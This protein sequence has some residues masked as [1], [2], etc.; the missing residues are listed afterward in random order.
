MADTLVHGQALRV[1][2]LH[3]FKCCDITTT[4]RQCATCR[5]DEHWPGTQSLSSLPDGRNRTHH[6]SF[7]SVQAPETQAFRLS[8]EVV[9]VAQEQRAV[10]VAGFFQH[11][12]ATL[13]HLHCI[14]RHGLSSRNT[15]PLHQHRQRGKKSGS[16]SVSTISPGRSRRRC[17]AYMISPQSPWPLV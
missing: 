12:G 2:A 5:V 16:S 17:G 14:R 13:I 11:V 8:L 7:E 9:R 6:V 15:H 10:L 4:C 1:S 3:S